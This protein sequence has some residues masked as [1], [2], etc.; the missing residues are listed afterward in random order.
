[1]PSLFT[2][3]NGL[4]FTAKRDAS[5]GS[6]KAKTFEFIAMLLLKIAS[7]FFLFSP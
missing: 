1:M 7:I 5:R 6:E 4:G 2:S 3:L